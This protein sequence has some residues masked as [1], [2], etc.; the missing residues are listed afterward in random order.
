M[1]GMRNEGRV[2]QFWQQH[3]LANIGIVT[4]AVAGFIV[5]DVD[6]RHDGDIAL[7]KFEELNGPLPVT[8]KVRT[9]G[10]GEHIFFEH[11]GHPIKNRAGILPGIDIRGDGGYI[12]APPSNHIS[13]R[14]YEWE[15][16]CCLEDQPL[17]P[18]PKGFTEKGSDKTDVKPHRVENSC[19]ANPGN[20]IPEGTRNGELYK[21]AC[22]FLKTSA[23]I[24]T[25]VRLR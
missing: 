15:S 11:P 2:R 23:L 9:G 1:T 24:S 7:Q 10:D 20:E 13:G 18:I 12:V 8:P 16:G 25:H 4:G 3:P 17:A 21:L 6:P 22:S 19:P 14:L 5:V